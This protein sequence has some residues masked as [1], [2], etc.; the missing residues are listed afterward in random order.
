MA[1]R[2]LYA[3]SP[4]WSI[5]GGRLDGLLHGPEF[6]VLKKTSRTLA[7]IAQLDGV[8]VFV[9]RV[10]SGSWVKGIIIRVCGSRARKTINGAEILHGAGFSHP[11]LFAAVE[12][13]Q[14]GSV[15]NSYVVVE[16]LHRPKI[17]SRFALADGH[18]FRWRR[19]LSERLAHT[20]RSLHDAGCYTRDLQETNLMLEAQPSGLKIYFVDLEDFRRLPLV[21]RRLR[22]LNLI[23]LDRSIGRFVSRAHRLRFFY[24]YLGEKPPRAEARA[25][26][27][28]LHEIYQRIERRNLRHQRS[29]AIVTPIA[30]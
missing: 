9:K 17:L 16:Y 11:R 3:S 6:R 1:S 24:N 4:D 22:M 20:I 28:R 19:M 25:L 8:E 29:G 27:A 5:V 13:Y 30:D 14:S 15:R 10:T 21:P 18:D 26:I 2:V 7:G 23:H 12:Q